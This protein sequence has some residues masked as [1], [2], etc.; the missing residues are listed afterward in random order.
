MRGRARH[1]GRPIRR[2][3]WLAAV[4]TATIAA[5]GCGGSGPTAITQAQQSGATGT[6]SRSAT[7]SKSPATTST[8]APT[9]PGPATLRGTAIAKLPPSL[10]GTEWT[11]LPTKRKVVALTFD[12]GANAAGVDSI[13]ATLAGKHAVA[14]FFMCGRW[15]Q[16]FPVRARRIAAR[17]PIG[18]HTY[19]H[20]RLTQLSDAAVRSE[21]R[22]GAAAIRSV[23]GHDPRPLFRFPYGDRD[24]RVIRI[25]NSLGYGAIGWTVDTLGWKGRRGGQSVSTVVSR[26]LN[27]LRP[28][29]IVLMHVGSAPDGS[30][31]DAAALPQLIDRIRARGY[32]LVTVAAYVR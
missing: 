26:V 3:A 27:G 15:A 21:V 9:T 28:G 7:T 14:T 8:A 4:A 29:A 1:I 18:N 11:R 2:Y 13:L 22:R 25:V 30:T 32:G 12:C 5:A 20:P 6:A 16:Y 23:T 24:A 17:Y 31:L 10:I 19:S